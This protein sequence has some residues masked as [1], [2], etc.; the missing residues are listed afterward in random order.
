MPA[1]GSSIAEAR[2]LHEEQLQAAGLNRLNSLLSTSLYLWTREDMSDE[3]ALLYMAEAISE[4]EAALLAFVKEMSL[5]ER[6]DKLVML[7]VA[8][9]IAA[10]H[11]S[12]VAM[13]GGVMKFASLPG[14]LGQW[15]VKVREVL[16]YIAWL[17]VRAREVIEK[18]IIPGLE[19]RRAALKLAEAL[20][21]A[22]AEL[23]R[24]CDL[25]KDEVGC[26]KDLARQLLAETMLAGVKTDKGGEQ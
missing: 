7:S 24:S 25:D 9:G 26:G 6:P 12:R 2:P 19:D 5:Y 8:K 20:V 3:D 23:H 17:L 16:E 14:L 21:L 10:D 18:E 4:N 22:Q 11:L 15:E 1:P 13:R